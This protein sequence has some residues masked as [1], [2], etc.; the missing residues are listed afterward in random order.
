MSTVNKRIRNTGFCLVPTMVLAVLHAPPAAAQ[1]GAGTQD[2]KDDIVEELVVTGSH[3]RRSGFDTVS[4]LEVYDREELRAQGVQTMADAMRFL[5][6]NTGAN[7]N[8]SRGTQGDARGEANFNLRGLGSA[9][10][11]VLIN[12]RRYTKSPQV[13]ETGVRAVDLN[14]LPMNMIERI[15]ILKSGAS[16]IYGSDGV[17]GVV[18]V[19]TRR[20]FEGFEIDLNYMEIDAGGSYESKGSLTAGITGDKGYATAYLNIFER[21]PMVFTDGTFTPDN[22]FF[23]TTG[24]PAAFRVIGPGDGMGGFAPVVTNIG[25]FPG[26]PEG[27][28]RVADPDC[29][30]LPGQGDGVHRVTENTTTGETRCL[31]DIVPLLQLTFPETRT[32]LFVEGQHEY[33]DAV[34]LYGE[35]S[36]SDV[37]VDNPRPGQVGLIG[38]GDPATVPADHPANVFGVPLKYVGAIVNPYMDPS[39][40][41]GSVCGIKSGIYSN[42]LTLRALGGMNVEIGDS[43]NLDVNYQWN[44][45][46][47]DIRDENLEVDVAATQLAL[48]GRGGFDGMSLLNPFASSYLNPELANSPEL[49]EWLLLSLHDIQTVELKVAEATLS[50]EF[51]RIGD[52]PI[53]W[54]FGLQRREEELS[55]DVDDTTNQNLDSPGTPGVPDAFGTQEINAAYAEAA[56]DVLDNLELQLALRH[57]DYSGNI[58]STTDPKIAM[59]WDAADWLALRGSFGTSFRG[60][61]IVNTSVDTFGSP[62]GEDPVRLINGE[63]V[64]TRTSP[65][66]PFVDDRRDDVF[67]ATRGGDD[68]RPEESESIDFGAVF[69]PT[70]NLRFSIDYWSID[71]TDIMSR[72]PNGLTI[73]QNDC[74]DD[75]LPNDPRVTRDPTTGRVVIVETSWINASSV[76]TSG[77]D[78]SASYNWETNWGSFTSRLESTYVSKFDIQLDEGGAVID[79][80][81]SRNALNPF[82]SVP[83]LRTNLFLGWSRDNHA[84]NAILR[85]IGEYE[86]DNPAGDDDPT[87]DSMLMVDLRYEYLLDAWDTSIAVGLFNAFDEEVPVVRSAFADYDARVHDPRGRMYYANLTVRF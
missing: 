70:D 79:G 17:A 9:T 54:A 77:V 84:A 37:S 86:D 66:D 20:Q 11:L 25:T 12:G 46:K 53:G 10:T 36:F 45:N 48:E 42:I 51:G 2:E 57:E 64:C 16:A 72:G 4:N 32:Q 60:P 8:R 6:A 22:I 82:R 52:R 29:L 1:Q 24:H 87:I 21:T 23:S 39:L 40:C 38:F 65:S 50:G 7:L 19:I 71:Y 31:S 56:L 62:G 41:P 83:D 73:I 33:S 69:R 59:R 44:K 68:L 80:A 85:Y 67:T 63:L 18:N 3:I 27:G 14:S 47:S 34:T 75:G 78:I 30:N 74:F 58:G 26:G 13:D 15:E 81:G 55:Y 35:A 43:W 5:T 28:V 49:I 61:D 76:E